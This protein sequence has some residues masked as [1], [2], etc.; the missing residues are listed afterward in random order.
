MSHLDE[1]VL[2]AL[3]DGRTGS[4][5]A[6]AERHLASCPSCRKALEATR[7]REREVASTLA[8]LDEP[9][10]T[11]AAR[12]AV[13]ARLAPGT[14]TTPG[15]ARRALRRAAAVVL[16]FGVGSAAYAMPGSPLRPWLS[17]LGGGR[18][19]ESVTTPQ[20]NPVTSSVETGVHLDV[21]GGPVRIVLRGVVAGTEIDVRLVGGATVSVMAP[22]GTRFTTGEG[23]IEATTAPGTV[24]VE[25]PRG[26]HPASLEVAGRTYLRVTDSGLDVVGPVIDRSDGMIRFAVPAG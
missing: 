10:D 19:T 9:F 25:L 24:H 2:T 18:D 8:A 3:R 14:S 4:D 7:T 17:H 11:D 6:A 13:R 1:A 16:L 15:P 20:T 23:R 22:R 5:S 12:E 21:Q 26:V